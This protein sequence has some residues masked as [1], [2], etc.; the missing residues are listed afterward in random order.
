[1]KKYIIIMIASLMATAVQAQNI[2]RQEERQFYQKA[3]EVIVEYAQSSSLKNDQLK[4]R[5]SQLFENQNVIVCNDLMVLSD[6]KTLPLWKYIQ[7]LRKVS[8]TETHVM[9]L[10]KGVI[11]DADSVW[12]MDVKFDKRISFVN[13][14]ECFSF[15]DSRE[16]FKEE[17]YHLIASLAMDKVT[18]KCYITAIQSDG[19]WQEFPQDYRILQ[20]SETDGRDLKL[21]INGQRV[22]KNMYD[23]VFLRPGDVITYNRGPVKE[24]TE[25]DNCGHIIT[26][27]YSDDPW[28][29][30]AIAGFSLSGFNK[31]KSENGITMSDDSEMS[32]GIEVG[33]VFKTQGNFKP[34]IFAGVNFSNNSYTLKTQGNIEDHISV[35]GVEEEDGDDYNRY[36]KVWGNGGAS[37]KHSATDLTIPLYVDLEY[38]FTS[39]FSVY[40]D[41]G[42]K[43]H[44][45]S[46]KWS[47]TLDKFETW[48]K[49][50]DKYD[51]LVIRNYDDNGNPVDN[52]VDLNDFGLHNENGSNSI[53]VDETNYK[54]SSSVDFMLGLGFRFNV[55][56]LIAVDVGMQYQAGGK[57]WKSEG[58]SMFSYTK[59]SG[60]RIDLLQ[61]AGD[62]SRGA[63]RLTAGL[64]FKF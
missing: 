41:L 55:S 1:M 10:R 30:K 21:D 39:L 34:G 16:V 47:A 40:A 37:Q 9:N 6:K 58:S 14:E 59:N 20:L 49:Y 17:D 62:I 31:L 61:K 2:S 51:G 50:G 60:D 32:Y 28:R 52:P 57:N 38:Q 7:E 5:F 12:T 46:G 45:P 11:E 42:F 13:E 29:V 19:V 15:F 36:Y 3:H 43:F 22:R 24:T 54:K 23:Q 18:G 64:I 53:G 44:M 48:G 27:S 25:D 35:P 4:Y 33:Y 56:K 8:E 63:L 26:V